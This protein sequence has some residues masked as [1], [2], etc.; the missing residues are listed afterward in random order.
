M[1]LATR[2]TFVQGNILENEKLEKACEGVDGVFHLAGIVKHSR[3]NGN[4]ATV[5]TAWQVNVSR[6][7]T[8]KQLDLP[9]TDKHLIDCLIAVAGGRD[10][11]GLRGR[12]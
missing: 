7:S 4:G 5:E 8:S 9:L 11:R 2:I 12:R 6:C 3:D 10:V 1:E